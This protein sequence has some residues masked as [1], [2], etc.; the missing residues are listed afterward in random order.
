MN[1]RLY[2]LVMNSSDPLGNA[3]LSI[4]PGA[5][6]DD[7][8][9]NNAAAPHQ[10]DNVETTKNALWFQEDPG[11]HNAQPAFPGATNARVWRYDLATG[12][13][14]VVAEVDQ[15]MSPIVNKGTWE[16]SGIVDA[17]SVFGPG[18]FLLDV[19]AHQ[20]DMPAG[21]GND[22]PAVPQRE[23]GQLLLMRGTNP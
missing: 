18:A 12:I 20:W 16:S 9:Y 22:P 17:S 5:N 3:T 4:L 21:V 1:G 14:T 11:S 6:F 8:G 23:R 7:L 13:S 15:S 10:P 2:K 19:Q